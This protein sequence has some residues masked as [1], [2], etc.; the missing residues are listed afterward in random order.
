[1]RTPSVSEMTK[2]YWVGDFCVDLSRNQISHDDQQQNLP[3]KVLQVLTILAQNQG[4][5]VS[6]EQLLD[7]V[8]PNIMVTPN[9]LQSCIAQLRKALKH[10][11]DS[12]SMIK[13]HSKQGYSLE[14][15]VRWNEEIPSVAIQSEATQ[16]QGCG[17][18]EPTSTEIPSTVL[19][20]RPVYFMLAI[21]TL[22]IA[23]MTLVLYQQQKPQ[24]QLNKLRNITATDFKEYNATYSADGEFILFHR[25]FETTCSNNLWAKNTSSLAEIQL[26]AMRGHY[27]SHSL[28]QDGST[29]VFVEQQDCNKPITRDTCFNL[30]SMDLS[31]A[32][33]QP[34]IPTKLLSCQHS[35]IKQPV[36][37][38]NQHIAL[39][40]KQDRNWRLINYDVSEGSSKILFESDRIRS[41]NF[42]VKHQIF[43]VIS[44]KKDGQQHIETL[45]LEGRKKSSHVIRLPDNIPP[46]IK[47]F[48]QFIPHSEQL[49]FS[50]KEQLF[51]LS[52][53]GLVEE[54]A[55]HSG[56]DIGS[57]AFHP[58]DSRLLL[59][60]GINDRDVARISLA[61]KQESEWAA[62]VDIN[63]LEVIQRSNGLEDTARFQPNGPAIAFV[64]EQTGTAQ[65]WLFDGKNATVISDF[66][67]G[68]YIRSLFW[69]SDG[70]GLLVLANIRLH[71]FSL[72]RK[73]ESLD[74]PYP[75]LDLFHWDSNTS[76]VIANIL[77]DGNR[78]L[79]ELQPNSQE[80]Q[81][82]NQKIVDWAAQTAEGKLLFMDS[83]Y[84][85]WQQG[86]VENKLI[87]PLANMG[88]SR[89]FVV[90]NNVIFGID[91]KH[92]L[93]SYN[94]LSNR[95]NVLAGGLQNIDYLNDLKDKELLISVAV[96][97]KREIIE[98]EVSNL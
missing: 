5:V 13:T 38:D 59:V 18:Q 58:D 24:L 11:G 32:L 90:S 71:H 37:I 70:Q 65:V 2:K 17:I 89:R 33:L 1:M 84:R 8:W 86:T 62:H 16:E 27:G 30:L 67:R 56:V 14:S 26:T 98:L 78:K 39:L 51:G 83:Q 73:K 66:A 68:N 45:D 50:Y 6:Y 63:T 21:V 49:L 48:P 40:Q 79:V 94:L 77:V 80:Y 53:S 52:T 72:N 36:W 35:Q 31:E 61:S 92:Q 96:A 75:I 87:V 46:Y 74:F 64:S 54:I 93:W 23:A 12:R 15:V 20:R 34:Q 55:F 69:D 22:V 57:L 60:N 28:S 10:N 85:F 88:S 47:V 76:E 44:I 41:F 82:I 7:Q 4:N 97:D 91:K 25:F 3:P 19:S 9:T 95:L 42:S 81:V 43:I 29:L